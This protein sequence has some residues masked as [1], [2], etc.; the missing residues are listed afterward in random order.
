MA[1]VLVIGG[2][3][4]ET[5]ESFDQ[6]SYISIEKKAV[7]TQKMVFK[8]YE[9]YRSATK[10]LYSANYDERIKWEESKGFV[11]LGR[12]SDEMYLS[13]NKEKLTVDDL[14]HIINL[15]P[16][17][18]QLT[19]EENG[20]YTFESALWDNIDR[21]FVNS[22]MMYQIGNRVYKVLMSGTISSGLQNEPELKLVNDFNIESYKNNPIFSVNWR[23]KYERKSLKDGTYNYGRFCDQRVTNGSQRTYLQINIDFIDL[24]D[25]NF[26]ATRSTI[27]RTNYIVRPYNRIALV[28]YWC[29]RTISCDIHISTDYPYYSSSNTYT[30][31]NDFEGHFI[32]S[33]DEDY[34]VQ[35]VLSEYPISLG[36]YATPIAHFRGY[37]C[38]GDTPSTDPK[39]Q[40]SI[41][42]QVLN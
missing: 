33:G 23:S 4:K 13:L 2:C 31:N 35:G 20:E 8:D 18:F 10:F 36:F 37:N 17:Y 32:E 28:W 41:N 30:W 38:W 42:T 21:Y 34:V 16:G 6:N 26:P 1:M 5:N 29:Q 9:D 25:P 24:G 3:K 11:S 39:V 19:Q 15:Y 14:K 27:E 40:I 7:S 22:D 12:V